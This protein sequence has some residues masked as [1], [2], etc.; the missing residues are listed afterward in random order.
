[1]YTEASSGDAARTTD[2]VVK[3]TI[4]AEEGTR[5]KGEEVVNEIAI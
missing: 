4:R 1:M 3:Q 2:H 5:K